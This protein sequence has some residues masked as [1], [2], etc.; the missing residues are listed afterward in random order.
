[1]LWC[2]FA[3]SV[4]L[5]HVEA[6]MDPFTRQDTAGGEADTRFIRALLQLLHLTSPEAVGRVIALEQPLTLV[7]LPPKLVWSFECN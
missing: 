2:C 5:L 1:M 7:V 6:R 3:A 4:V